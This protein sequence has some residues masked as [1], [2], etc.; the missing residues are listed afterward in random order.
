M[1]LVLTVSALVLLAVLTNALLVELP[2]GL[3]QNYVPRPWP[4][5]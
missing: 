1:T 2:A 3:L 5:R 4:F